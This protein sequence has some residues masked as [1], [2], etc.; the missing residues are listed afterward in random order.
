MCVARAQALAGE[1]VSS[2]DDGTYGLVVT[3][4]AVRK[5]YV[6][7]LARL[8]LKADAFSDSATAAGELRLHPPAIAILEVEH[9]GCSLS[10]RAP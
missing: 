10:A 2:T 4:D 3:G 8:G 5:D 6:H 7:L 9:G 1:V